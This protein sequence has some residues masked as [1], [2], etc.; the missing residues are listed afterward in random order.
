VK[1]IEYRKTLDRVT[2]PGLRK[3]TRKLIVHH[4]A[5]PAKETT[6]DLI[7][8]WHLKPRIWPPKRPWPH[9]GYHYCIP[10]DGRVFQTL[11]EVIRGIHA[12]GYNYESLAVC[13]FGNFEVEA[14]TIE[15][16][17]SLTDLFKAIAE[18]YGLT[19]WQ[20]YGHGSQRL[21]SV[22]PTTFT[23]CPGKNLKV[24]LPNIRRKV[25]YQIH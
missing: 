20:L 17:K 12:L 1:I 23:A 11:P 13:V 10:M 22:F 14:P 16:L 5:F 2:Y 4:S 21:C 25:K 7:E 15:Q 8:E 6:I 3:A 9:I 24:R 18:R 19:Y